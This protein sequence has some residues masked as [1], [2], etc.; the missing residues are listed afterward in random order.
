MYYNS[1]FYVVV[2][3]MVQRNLSGL[4]RVDNNYNSRRGGR[5]RRRQEVSQVQRKGPATALQVPDSL[6]RLC[7]EVGMYVETTDLFILQFVISTPIKQ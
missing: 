5:H 2:L 7:F 4:G 1:T 6:S 3:S